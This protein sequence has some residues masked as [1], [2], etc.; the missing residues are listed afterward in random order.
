MIWRQGFRR[1][2]NETVLVEEGLIER[3]EYETLVEAVSYYAG[4]CG[5]TFEAALAHIEAMSKNRVPL[6]GGPKETVEAVRPV[7]L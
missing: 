3:E 6:S 2:N 7:Q 5:V 4:A 1:K